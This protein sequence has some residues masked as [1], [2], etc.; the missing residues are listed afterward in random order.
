MLIFDECGAR[1]VVDLGEAKYTV[2][3]FDSLDCYILECA[4]HFC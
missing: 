1:R 2:A 4:G 3:R